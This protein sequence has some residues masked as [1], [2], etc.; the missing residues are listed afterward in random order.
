MTYSTVL[1]CIILVSY[2]RSCFQNS[3]FSSGTFDDGMSPKSVYIWCYDHVLNLN[4]TD[5]AE[6][7]LEVKKSNCSPPYNSNIPISFL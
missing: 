1:V 7:V 4:D 6:H 2:V 5:F 3:R